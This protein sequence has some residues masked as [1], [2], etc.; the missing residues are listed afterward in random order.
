LRAF[1][2]HHPVFDGRT[3]ETNPNKI[4]VQVDKVKIP[5]TITCKF[6]DLPSPAN[7]LIPILKIKRAKANYLRETKV[8]FWCDSVF[9][10][11]FVIRKNKNVL[12]RLRVNELL[13]SKKLQ[14]KFIYEPKQ[15]TKQT[16]TNKRKSFN[17]IFIFYLYIVKI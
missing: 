3:R 1:C 2:A 4:S 9:S 6:L 14:N 11:F 7:L 13:Q 16:K 8:R 17:F 15:T 10:G 5:A 12:F